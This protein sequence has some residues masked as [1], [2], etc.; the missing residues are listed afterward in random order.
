MCKDKKLMSKKPSVGG[1]EKKN[2]GLPKGI[3][4]LAPIPEKPVKIRRR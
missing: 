3:G 1:F 2:F 4:I